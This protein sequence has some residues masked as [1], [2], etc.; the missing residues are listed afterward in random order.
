[1]I[2]SPCLGA[3]L[4]ACAALAVF[5]A[6]ASAAPPPAPVVQSQQVP[7]ALKKIAKLYSALKD[8]E[9]Y[10]A[11]N[12]Y[13]VANPGYP[14]VVEMRAR[15]LRN[16]GR[17]DEAIAAL[18]ALPQ[19]Q[20]SSKLLLAECL[21]QTKDGGR[22]AEQLV[23]EVAADD[24]NGVDARITRA[25]VYIA[26]RKFEEAAT[27]LKYAVAQAPKNYEANLLN[28]WM[29]D[30]AGQP[31]R[32]MQMYRPL[33]EKP[34]EYEKSDNHHVRDAAIAFAGCFVK[35][36]QYDTAIILYQQLVERF[37][38]NM[39]LV[40]K[41]GVMQMMK[42]HFAEAAATLEKGVATAPQNGEMRWRLGDLY[43]T[44]DRV[45][46]AIAQFEAL[47]ALHQPNFEVLAELRLGDLYLTKGV[48]DKAKLMLETALTVAPDSAD[49]LE[50]NGRLR[51]KLGDAAGAKDAYRKAFAKEPLKFDSL[52]HLTQLLAKSEDP[53]EK[54]E[55]TALLERWKKIQPFLQ[56]MDLARQQLALSPNHAMLQTRLASLL[57][58]AGE[59]E[60]AKVQIER[61]ARISAQNPAT[62]VQ[63]GYISANLKDWSMALRSFQRARQLITKKDSDASPDAV[64]KIEGFIEKLKKGEELPLP[65]GEYNRPAQPANPPDAPPPAGN[66]APEKKDGTTKEPAGGG[67]A[68]PAVPADPKKDGH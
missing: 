21:A 5:S 57:N 32:A 58:L 56:E 26:A 33:C 11:C 36:Q 50:A 17:Y 12:E 16:L 39:D 4:R 2:S 47:Y 66:G 25:R 35:Q 1:V 37:P 53:K 55:G 8:E 20:P 34:G 49:V 28:A 38:E 64:K 41:L 15:C 63:M 9:A 44:Q 18:K 6:L 19:L 10:A 67:A 22:D 43:R 7:E 31:E 59:Y 23:N 45:D 27:E 68:A 40:L 52:Y 24:P 14:P 30:I 65:M 46:D 54:E 42:L 48:M 51:E 60:Q 62:F 3:A 13:L 61:A 29:S